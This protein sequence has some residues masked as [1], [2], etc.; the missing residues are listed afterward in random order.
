MATPQRIADGLCPRFSGEIQNKPSLQI[1]MAV[2]LFIRGPGFVVAAVYL[3]Y[4]DGPAG[5]LSSSW[6]SRL[7]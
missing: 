6:L 4:I 3:G 1:E 7:L 5:V 2:N